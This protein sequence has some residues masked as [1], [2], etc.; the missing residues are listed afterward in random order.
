MAL[1]GNKA[2]AYSRYCT[3]MKDLIEI[4]RSNVYTMADYCRDNNWNNVAVWGDN[5]LGQ[6]AAA[7]IK[8]FGGN[9]FNVVVFTKKVIK[10]WEHLKYDYDLKKE[11]CIYSLTD[12]Y[13]CILVADYPTYLRFLLR[14]RLRKMHL[15]IPMESINVS[16]SKVKYNQ[17][18]YLLKAKMEENRNEGG[19]IH[20]TIPHYSQVC[21]DG[22]KKKYSPY[23][24]A[25]ST[26]VLQLLFGYK[27]KDYS[28]VCQEFLKQNSWIK[29]GSLVFVDDNKGRYFNR[30]NGERR[31]VYLQE[32][33]AN[34]IWLIGPCIVSGSYV[35]D[36]YTLASLLQNKINKSAYEGKYNVKA[37]ATIPEAVQ[38]G[39]LFDMIPLKKDDI[40]I[41]INSNLSFIQKDLSNQLKEA[42]SELLKKED[43]FIDEP[44]HCNYRGNEVV[45]NVLFDYLLKNDFQVDKAVKEEKKGTEYK[46]YSNNM[47][48]NIFLGNLSKK[49]I[50][51][52]NAGC[53]VMNCN[54]FTLG[55]RYLIEQ[56]VKTVNVLYCFVVEEDK[57][58]FSFQDRIH[59]V[60][61]GT[62]DLKNVVVIPSGRFIL[63]ADTF[64][65]YF[66]KEDKNIGKVD[67]SKDL[68]LFGQYVAPCL[69][70]KK[71]FVG[72]EPFDQV[73]RQ[74]NDAMKNIL[75]QYGVDVEIISRKQAEGVIISASEV[76]KCLKNK[77]FE[78][79]HTLVPES[80]YQ[81][82]EEKYL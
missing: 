20:L 14:K 28:E 25:K 55:H 65:E 9:E 27:E 71:R 4:E 80:T 1:L 60:E 59:L 47:D 13:D 64:S 36:K 3:G 40:V 7:S 41:F 49:K 24:T 67:V 70:I 62:K 17:V 23:V 63:S 39:R 33:A 22:S 77:D 45:V 10:G 6:A 51:T 78:K 52:S 75:P 32:H 2:L 56:A 15:G 35:E 38:Y 81:F 34:T 69:N 44:I 16:I 54:P 76:R 72:E 73:T 53:I 68:F 79:I 5:L 61:E 37:V 82:L 29:K 30:V 42:F 58:F 43:F 66:H 46:V 21:K 12:N 26:D 57:S 48:L 19:G 50:H 18:G 31:N 11:K 8:K 74:Y